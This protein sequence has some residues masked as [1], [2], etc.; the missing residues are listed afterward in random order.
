MTQPWPLAR[1][2]ES[3][4]ELVR[5]VLGTAQ[6][7]RVGIRRENGQEF[8]LGGK[9]S[10]T[11]NALLAA[12]YDLFTEAG[13]RGTS[14]AD[15]AA[16]AGVSLGTFYQYFHDR[17]DI[18]STLVRIGVL[19]LLHGNQRRWDPARGRIG[20]RRIIAG[21]VE[22]YVATA[23]FQA[24]WEEVTHVEEDMA[25][26]RR[27]LA[28]VFTNAIQDAIAE[29][30]AAGIVR[31]DLDASRV[32]LALAAM[33]DRYCYVTYVFDPPPGPAPSV[34]DTADLLTDL[35]ADALGLVETRAELARSR[36][37]R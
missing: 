1:Q 3:P 36:R 24:V 27:D 20:L 32:A 6:A 35:W 9:A 26:L 16:R 8:P 15:I 34:D 13:Y 14:V 37:A 25:E 33:V 7:A 31:C 12:A 2:D 23:S 28:R 30:A 17:A 18:L 21:F 5:R 19:E 29:G 10:R 22:A 11:R 4:D